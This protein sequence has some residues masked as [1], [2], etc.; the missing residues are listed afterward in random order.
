MLKRQRATPTAA[1]G[2]RE[3]VELPQLNVSHIKVKVDTGARSSALHL[4][5]LKKIQRDGKQMVSFKIHPLQR[6]T[7]E[8]SEAEAEVLEYRHIRSSGGHVTHRPVIQTVVQLFQQRWV[9]LLSLA[10]GDAMGF[11]MLLGGE[12]V[13]G[14]FAHLHSPERPHGVA[15]STR[16][17]Q[18][19]SA[20]STLAGGIRP[21]LGTRRPRVQCAGDDSSRSEPHNSGSP[22]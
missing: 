18:P 15:V 16:G 21:A 11:R 5:D 20:S 7:R 2:W 6:S 9:I 14:R 17:F 4:F 1:I 10:S 3:W 8:T 12:A 19:R 22:R 13:R